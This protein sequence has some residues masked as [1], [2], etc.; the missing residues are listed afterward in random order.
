MSAT[1]NKRRKLPPYVRISRNEAADFGLD[2]DYVYIC[3]K[4]NVYLLSQE[5]AFNH[6]KCTK[7]SP[8]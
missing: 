7:I 8:V 2:M 3:N 5:A 1:I 4:C 6:N